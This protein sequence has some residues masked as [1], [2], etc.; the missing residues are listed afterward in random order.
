MCTG[1]VLRFERAECHQQ[2]TIVSLPVTN[3]AFSSIPITNKRKPFGGQWYTPANLAFGKWRQKE[4]EF[5]VILT[6]EQ[7]R[8]Q[9][10]VRKLLC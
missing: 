5:K 4:Q 7:S 1:L 9:P 8:G 3:R 2:S 6:T 10:E